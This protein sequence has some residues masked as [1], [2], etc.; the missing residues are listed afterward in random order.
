MDKSIESE[1]KRKLK[2][3]ENT[4]NIWWVKVEVF[5]QYDKMYN[6]T[7]AGNLAGYER[8][9]GYIYIKIKGKSYAAHSIAWFLHYGMW[10]DKIL[11]HEDQN[12]SNNRISNLRQCSFSENSRNQKLRSTNK[13]GVVGVHFCKSTKKWVSQIY[14]NGVQKHLG[15]F[16]TKAEAIQARL[17]KQN[18]LK[19]HKNHGRASVES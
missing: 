3:D 13:S 14:D 6:T 5:D 11:D 12:K 17:D 2:Y 18:E 10:P 15:R 8:P 19:Y 1:I 9:D 16:S 4:G 7:I